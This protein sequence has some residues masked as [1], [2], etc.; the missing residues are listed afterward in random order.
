MDATLLRGSGM[1]MEF[2]KV[3][4]QALRSVDF[5][6]YSF[7][8]EILPDTSG[9]L[10]AYYMDTCV[11]TGEVERQNTRWWP[12]SKHAVLSEIVQ[13]MFKCVITSKEHFTREHFLYNDRPVFGPHFDVDA[14]WEICE[15]TDKRPG[16]KP[17]E[18]IF[19]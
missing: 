13:T 4:W 14:L 5:P 3:F 19:K 7:E 6:D 10:R 1:L 11:D 2:E 8:G 18:S 17:S 15:R 9:R 16:P 12:V